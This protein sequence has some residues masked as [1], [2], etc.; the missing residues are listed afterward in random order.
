MEKILKQGSILMI[1]FSLVLFASCDFQGL[2]TSKYEGNYEGV[3]QTDKEIK[4]EVLGLAVGGTVEYGEYGGKILKL[5]GV[6]TSSSENRVIL[7]SPVDASIEVTV[8]FSDTT[9]TYVIEKQGV[10]VSGSGFKK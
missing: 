6:L 5:Q 3:H 1:L 8:T 7:R 2:L 4:L 9:F 10:T